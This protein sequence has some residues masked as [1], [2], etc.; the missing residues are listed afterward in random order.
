MN[1][2]W[3][4]YYIYLETLRRSGV[5]NMYG[6]AIYLQEHFDMDY[7]LAVIILG[8]WMD[9]YDL[10]INYLTQNNLIEGEN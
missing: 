10:I 9:Y 1:K 5:T 6:A 3:I 4:N 8:N 7:S 2:N